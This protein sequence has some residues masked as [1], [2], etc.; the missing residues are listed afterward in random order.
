MLNLPAQVP[1]LDS[2]PSAQPYLNLLNLTLKYLNLNLKLLNLML[3][4]L[5]LNLKLL[6]FSLNPSSSIQ[7]AMQH[8]GIAFFFDDQ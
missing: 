3:K 6:N 2:Q 7:V 8:I 4:Y 1:Q 5:N